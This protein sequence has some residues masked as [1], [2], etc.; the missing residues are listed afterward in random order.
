MGSLPINPDIDGPTDTSVAALTALPD[1]QALKEGRIAND[2]SRG[3]AW[4]TIGFFVLVIASVPL[5]QVAGEHRRGE[6]SQALDVFRQRP[7]R[8]ANRRFEDGLAQASSLRRAAQPWLQLGLSAWGGFGNTDVVLGRAG[9]MYYAPGVSYVTGPGFLSDA[10]A[11]RRRKRALDEGARPPDADPIPAIAQFDRDLRSRGIRLLL[12]PVPDKATMEPTPLF[13][14]HR[15][16]DEIVPPNNVDF[17]AFVAKVRGARIEIYDPTPASLY[18][19]DQ[20][21][22]LKHDTHWTPAWMETVARELALRAALPARETMHRA[23]I[24]R[25][26]VSNNGDLAAMLRLPAGQR[27]FEPQVV[28]IHPVSRLQAGSGAPPED[29]RVLLLGDSFTNIYSSPALGW[30]ESAGLAD[31]LGA[32]LGEP[33]DVIARN[34]AGANAT[35]RMLAADLARGVDRLAGKQLVIWEFAARELALGD[36]QS[37]RLGAPTAVPKGFFVA[38]SG[39]PRRVSGIVTARSISPRPGTVPYKDHIMTIHLTRLSTPDGM[40]VSDEAIVYLWSMRDNQ[41][42]PAAFLSIG[43]SVNIRL[44]NWNDVSATLEQLNRSEL[45]DTR[46]QLEPPNWG[47]LEP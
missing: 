23:V 36:W 44:S 45:D 6:R 4:L 7:S 8:E 15:R 40:P 33:V 19:A 43:Q 39:Q 37:I 11:G 34:D 1:E 12:L 30:G 31:H 14:A 28:E 21:R 18:M 16:P 41:Q 3:A 22:Y 10:S 17:A 47:E 13:A 9:W 26:A 25:R 46:M 38:P 20:P 27:A 32:A 42:M 5:I 2:I 35:R 24:G 29:V